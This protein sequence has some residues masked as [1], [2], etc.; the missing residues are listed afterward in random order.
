MHKLFLLLIIAVAIASCSKDE[1]S[2]FL[3][4]KTVGSGSVYETKIV[5]DT[6]FLIAGSSEA[7]PLFLKCSNTGVAEFS[8]TSE[9]TGVYTDIADDDDGYYLA[10]ASGEDLLIT[11]LDMDGTEV[12]DTI[13]DVSTRVQ[14]AKM[15]WIDQDYFMVC[16]GN[17]P[18]SLNSNSF[19]VLIIGTD[20]EVSQSV[21]ATPGFYPSITGLEVYSPSEI[22]VSLTKNYGSGKSLSSVARI[23]P[24]GGIIWETELFN[25]PSYAAASNSLDELNDMLYIT[26]SLERISDDKTLVNSFVASVTISGVLGT[27]EFLENSNSGA[28]SDFNKDGD[29]VV[30]NRNCIILDIGAIPLGDDMARF[31]VLDVCD[32]YDTDVY[33]MS[34][35]AD[36]DGNYLIGGSSGGKFYYALRSGPKE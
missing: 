1:P 5:D 30:L 35:S 13:I 15:D 12:W 16:A 21:S 29:L 23:T 3:W 7:S 6:L 28:D 8:Y 33:G 4:E 14:I 20:G 24:E 26:G 9:V 31:R 22:F 34:L 25:N 36:P 17:D 2:E 32:S 10:G 19:E 18:D 11:H 27:K